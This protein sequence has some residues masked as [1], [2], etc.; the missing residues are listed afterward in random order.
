MSGW[1]EIFEK[2][3][4]YRFKIPR[5]FKPGMLTDGLIYAD[6]A[7]IDHIYRENA[8]V[9][10]ANVACL[11]GIVG[12]SLAMPDIHFGYG[13]PIGGVAAFDP[14]NEGII[15][16]GGVG[17]DINCL[18]ADSKVLHEF[19]YSMPIKDF[20]TK[21]QQ[22]KIK[23]IKL[24]PG[25]PVDTEIVRFIKFTPKKKVFRVT[26]ATGRT[27]VA[28]EDHPFYTANGMRPLN[29]VEDKIA[30]Y[31]FEGVAYEE[32]SNRVLLDKN[33]VEQFLTK[34]LNKTKKGN[35]LNQILKKLMDDNLFPLRE[36]SFVL[37]Y[38]IK[39]IGFVFG[40]GSLVFLKG[41][42]KATVW[43]YGLKEDLEK[44]R[45]DI[46][47][48][49][50]TPSKVYSRKRNCQIKSKYGTNNFVH[51]EYSFKV[52]SIAFAALLHLLGV[53]AGNKASQSYTVPRW[54][55]KAPLWQKRLFLA[56]LFGA[57]LSS[58]STVTSHD[59]NFYAPVLSLNKKQAF[60]RNGKIFL[61]EIKRLLQEFG[62]KTQKIV[63]DKHQGHRWRLIISS[64]PQNLINLWTKVGFEYH[65]E[66]MF[67][68]CVAAHYL[69]LKEL[70]LK[71][72]DLIS[73]SISCLKNEGFGKNRIFKV[74]NNHINE[75]FIE[76]SM[77]EGR[78]TKPRIGHDFVLFSR[79]LNEIIAS[80]GKSGMVWDEIICRDEC[81]EDYVYDFTVSNDYHNFVAD[82]FVVSNCG[83]RV[84]RTDLEKKD[85]EPKIK[86]IVAALATNV[87][88]GVGSE[89]DLSLS[90][91]DLDKLLVE[92]S[93]WAVKHGY[94]TGDDIEHT[95]SRGAMPGADPS[96]VSS[97]AKERGT[98]QQ[99]T[100]G[101]GNH[102][103]EVQYIEEIYDEKIAAA[104]GLFVGQV[105]IMVHSGSRG[106]GHQ[107]CTDYIQVMQKATQKY[108]IKLPDRQLCCA[109]VSSPEGKDYFG[110]MAAAA[111][112]AWCNRQMLMH[113]TCETFAQ[114]IGGSRAK[115]GI[116]LIYDVA[117][118]IAKMERHK[119][120]G[121][122]DG[123][124]ESKEKVLCVHRK[125]ATRAFPAGHP[126]LS[127]DYK[128]TGQP[129]L[130][131]GDM[132]RYSYLL[133]GT[134]LAMKETWGSICHGA[135]RLMSRSEASRRFTAGQLIS[136]L[137][138]KGIYVRSASKKG[139]VEEAPGAYKDVREVV[140][141]VHNSGLARKVARMKPMGVVKG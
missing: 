120:E 112:Y 124:M 103:V 91:K 62:V 6:E 72:R 87:P 48:I 131:P 45:Q 107:V 13:F 49:G 15:S 95:E 98:S 51:V 140:D 66:K 28:T 20:E 53:P 119:I 126:E 134:D 8:H 18:S 123:E 25:E 115:L 36:N 57:E 114:V 139:L 76:R 60:I 4:N 82:N 136:D 130:I 67:L 68:G 111:N 35:A 42:N 94:G 102:F 64:V 90:K 73:K 133:V 122:G 65:R 31:P 12:N 105:T 88:S 108:G 69:L 2:L 89:S 47:F 78:K 9:Q 121:W 29:E 81:S 21:W 38:L 118:N 61:Q 19:G 132:G 137:E 10:V 7:M 44:I 100:L 22:E 34:R 84:L 37:P 3:D 70:K 92:G 59:Y 55:F 79:Y 109:P 32:P 135:G 24:N 74:F 96:L 33:D 83:V 41:S 117:H 127:A 71:S 85:I 30:L 86:D 93:A 54:L 46:K 129:V 116:S 1:Q 104:W 58:P 106:F 56:A 5:T 11:P 99:G 77:Y 23:C 110:A 113:S 138:S 128:E 26:T 80:L 17:Y 14:E 40:D 75:R 101:S 63:Y 125:G 27:I 52:T 50:F 97:R 141:V 39:I 16:P 43:F